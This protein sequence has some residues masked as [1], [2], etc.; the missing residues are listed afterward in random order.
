MKMA[1][2]TIN[3]FFFIAFLISAHFSLECND[4]KFLG[5]PE[6]KENIIESFKKGSLIEEQM[7]EAMIH[8]EIKIINPF[9]LRNNENYNAEIV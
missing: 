1:T 8:P 9:T 2:K 3:L 6:P 5:E 4:N 7:R